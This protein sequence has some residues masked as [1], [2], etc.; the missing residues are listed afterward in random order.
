MDRQQGIMQLI[1]NK[2]NDMIGAGNQLFCMQFPAQPLNYR[3]YQYDTSDRHSVMAKPY[4]VQES[5]F[6]LSEELFDISPITAGSNGEKLSVV[7]NTLINNF[8]PQLEHLAPF[9]KDRAGLGRFLL[10]DSG[11]RNEQD[12]PI[13]RIELSKNLYKIYLEE[14]N[15]WNEEKTK[16]FD[17]YKANND[18]DGYAKWQSSYGMVRQEQLNNLYNDA[19]VR[20]H[21]HEVLTILGY[22]NASSIAEELELGKQKMRNSARSSLDE[23]MTVYPV[24]FQPN[25]WFKALTP[26][27]N[28]QDLTMA[29]DSIR[30]QYVAKQRELSRAK[31]E[32][33]QM[34]LLSVNQ[35]EID[36]LDGEIATSK[37]ALNQAESSLIQKY[38]EGVVGFAKIYFKATNPLSGVIDRSKKIKVN[39]DTAK[40]LGVLDLSQTYI[41]SLSEAVNG[42]A[43]T[44]QTQQKL[45]DAISHLTELKA[46]KAQLDSRDWKF[47]KASLEQRV[48]DL[49]VDVSAMADLLANVH[50][51][52]ASRISLIKKSYENETLTYEIVI[53][54]TITGGSFTLKTDISEIKITRDASNKFSLP[55]D[56][57]DLTLTKDGNEGSWIL[58]L[59]KQSK[60]SDIVLQKDDLEPKVEPKAEP[61]ILPAPQTEADA[62]VSGMFTDILL[63]I[64][65]SEETGETNLATAANSSKWGVSTWF[66]S[67]G[68]QSSS[69]SANASQ[70][71]NFFNQEI[72][73]GFRVAKVSF[74][75]GG[76][77]NPQIFKMSHAFCRLAEMRVSP[78][79]SIDDIKGKT[80]AQLKALTEYE[81]NKKKYKYI[82]PAFPV[83]M[84][85]A[86]DIT[87]KVKMD[88]IDST[89]AKSVVENSSSTGGGF[90][91]FSSS[92]ASS[93]KNSS[94]S[95]FHGVHGGYYYIRIPGPQVLGYFL[96]LVPQDNSV[97]YKPTFT[98]NGDSPV[99][100]AFQLYNH[101]K[102]L[103]D[104]TQ[105]QLSKTQESGK[106][107]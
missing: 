74:D 24:Q 4:S 8:I 39:N 22:L 102:E 16:K 73:I 51:V 41:D 26:N 87:I 96:Q 23:S 32:L 80:Q 19:V 100:Q 83:A 43:E 94:E 62:E 36:R 30:D 37:Q 42:I 98:D 1:Y 45:N 50:Q 47:N 18:L 66:N 48:K 85:I 20:G 44:S 95:T 89:S 67:V 57:Q 34:E 7:Y 46:R 99:I 84:V 106:A 12:Q 59:A 3:Q 70:Q 60:D 33:Q 31:A 86:K 107:N 82:M 61:S 35:N 97:P 52:N 90:F 21:L 71:S 25:N 104:L 69:S 65:K 76:W 103:M 79:L 78:G 13:S 9:I 10:E 68:G 54:E 91:G 29:Q 81:E 63:K 6:R 53:S 5:E 101:A 56:V 40:K 58:Q 17:E 92:G 64:S 72:E 11:E 28:P 55:D 2:I 49:Q 105:S 93:S 75:R 27:L 88:K 15:K 14:K 77:F 38:G